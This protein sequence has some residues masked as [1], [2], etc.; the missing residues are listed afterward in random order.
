MAVKCDPEDKVK[1]GIKITRGVS[2][3]ELPEVLVDCVS[4]VVL[5]MENIAASDSLWIIIRERLACTAV[6]VLACLC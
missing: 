3:V 5:P 6:A 4:P 1:A 2:Q